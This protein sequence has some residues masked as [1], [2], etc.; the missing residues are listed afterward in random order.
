MSVRLFL[1]YFCV[2]IFAMG[3]DPVG[4]SHIEANIPD[5]L[6]F[7][8]FLNRDL[9]SYFQKEYKQAVTVKYELLR[10]EPTQS[11]VSLPKYYI[12]I[13]IYDNLKK[14]IDQGAT[15]VAAREQQAFDVLQYIKRN[16]IKINPD[17]L[18]HI[19]P[20][21]VCKKIKKEFL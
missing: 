9:K 13:F 21:E 16:D 8:S 19:F 10:N 2:I 12:W 15:K 5:K 6:H 20:A 7:D 17:T 14:E 11:G 4:R 3:C 18:S 1:S